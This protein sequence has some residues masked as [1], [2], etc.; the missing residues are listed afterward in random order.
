MLLSPLDLAAQCGNGRHK[1]DLVIAV[2][3]CG[4]LLCHGAD[5]TLEFEMRREGAKDPAQATR[6]KAV[7]CASFLA[8]VDDCLRAVLRS[9]IRS[10]KRWVLQ[11][12]PPFAPTALER[13]V[14]RIS[15]KSSGTRRSGYCSFHHSRHPRPLEPMERKEW[16]SS[17]W[18]T[19]P[20]RHLSKYSSRRFGISPSRLKPVSLFARQ[21]G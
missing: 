3:H 13:V 19:K 5:L 8:C 20:Y 7:V 1:T 17:Q 14:T 6:A 2:H 9:R 11:T 12:N 16:A 10:A 18:S 4:C 15:I 21:I